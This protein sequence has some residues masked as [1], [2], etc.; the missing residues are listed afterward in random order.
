MSMYLLFW[1]QL[2]L[3]CHKHT[4]LFWQAV[5]ERSISICC[6]Y[7][8]LAHKLN[9]AV[10][11]CVKSIQFTCDFFCLLEALYIFIS[12]SKV[13]STHDRSS[14]IF[15]RYDKCR[16]QPMLSKSGDEVRSQTL[17]CQTCC[18]HNARNRSWMIAFHQ[19]TSLQL[20]A[21]PSC[22]HLLI[23]LQAVKK[24]LLVIHYHWLIFWARHP[25][26][27][28]ACSGSQ[29]KGKWHFVAFVQAAV[30]QLGRAWQQLAVSHQNCL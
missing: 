5:I 18:L 10:V 22:W 6:V 19:H 28:V 3:L 25:W 29:E 21:A 30:R 13:H 4:D 23:H 12:T 7:S 8:M 11:D 2:P 15:L 9:L 24:S 26:Y 17:S 14:I 20:P 27:G 16:T 1:V